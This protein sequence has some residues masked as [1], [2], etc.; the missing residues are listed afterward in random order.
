MK[1][2]VTMPDVSYEPVNDEEKKLV[3]LIV[4]KGKLRASKPKTPK[5]YQTTAGHFVHYDEEGSIKGEAAYVWRMI[6]F[7]VSPKSVHHCMP[8][9]ASFDMSGEYSV[10]HKRTDELDVIVEKIVKSVPME[11]WH[12]VNR[13]GKAF[14]M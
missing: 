14:G 11:N 6:A 12:G 2:K 3:D 4:I 9:T 8:M 7:Q 1:T 5:M 13:W 10:R